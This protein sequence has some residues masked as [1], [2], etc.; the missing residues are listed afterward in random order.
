MIKTNELVKS[1]TI[2]FNNTSGE[3]SGL[4]FQY[5]FDETLGWRIIDWLNGGYSD[6]MMIG[7]FIINKEEYDTLFLNRKLTTTLFDYTKNMILQKLHIHLNEFNY[8]Y[9]NTEEIGIPYLEK[10]NADELDLFIKEAILST[11]GV[12]E[13]LEFKSRLVSADAGEYG[14]N[15]VT[16]YVEFTVITETGDTVW[17]SIAI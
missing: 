11:T 16:Y 7:N 15:K 5:V 4:S 10:P 1:K 2:T 6:P 9:E 13:I 8:R 12:R 17:Q 14:K 3:Y